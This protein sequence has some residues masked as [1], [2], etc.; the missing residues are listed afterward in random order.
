MNNVYLSG[1]VAN[2]VVCIEVGA[3]MSV[4]IKK[5]DMSRHN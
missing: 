4:N 5:A 1:D 3:E 2:I